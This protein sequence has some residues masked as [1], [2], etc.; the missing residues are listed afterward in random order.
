MVADDKPGVIFNLPVGEG[1][2]KCN[3]FVPMIGDTELPSL[4][5]TRCLSDAAAETE[6]SHLKRKMRRWRTDAVNSANVHISVTL[7]GSDA[8]F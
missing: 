1:V 3:S 6:L 5:G 2:T 4:D 8:S 7:N